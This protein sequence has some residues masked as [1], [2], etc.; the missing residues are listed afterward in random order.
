MPCTNCLKTYFPDIN[1]CEEYQNI[2]DMN[3]VNTIGAYRCSKRFQ[4]GEMEICLGKSKIIFIPFDSRTLKILC[5][6]EIFQTLRQLL[7]KYFTDKEIIL[8]F[9]INCHVVY[10]K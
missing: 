5:D 4:S 2:C 9:L 3:C 1:E 10:V 6:E 8:F 7:I